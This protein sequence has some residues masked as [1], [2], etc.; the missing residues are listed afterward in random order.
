MGKYNYIVNRV[1]T[2]ST[3][4]TE[5]D[6]VLVG[7]FS[8]NST[9]DSSRDFI[10]LHIYTLEEELLK[11]QLN[12]KGSTQELGSSGAGK[13]GA[14]NIVINPSNDAIAN[15]FTNGDVLLKYNFF[16]DLLQL[17]STPPKY[18]IQN[19]SSDRLEIQLLTLEVSDS[20]LI[21]AVRA[22]KDKL[23]SQS[24][25]SDFKVNFGNNIL[26]TGVNIDTLEFKDNQS[27]IVKLYEP[28]PSKIGVKD[29]CTLLEVVSNSVSFTV[30]V[31]EQ[32]DVVKVPFL[33]GPNF[34]IEVAQ[35]SNVPTEFFNF[36]ELFSYPV[37]SSYYQLYS[38]FNEK[39][40][41]IS[42]DHSDFNDF[43]H[44][45]S[46][47]ERLRNFK[48]KLDLIHSYQDSRDAVKNTGY[49]KLGASGSRE[50]YDGLITGIVNNFDHYD[51]FLYYESGSHA[52]PKSNT[53]HPYI[54]QRSSTTKS[55]EWFNSK[56]TSASNYDVTN[57]DVLTNAIPSY[58]REDSQN[59]PLLMFVH[60]LGQHFDNLWIYFKAVSNKYDADNRL[61]FGISKD[62]VRGAIESFGVKV[63]NSNRN[64]ENLFSA[65]AGESYQSGSEVINHLMVITSGSGVE[66]L[67]PMPAD[68]YQKEIY[69]RIY[70]NL[71]LLTKSKGTFRGL[72]AL[73]NCFGIPDNI[74]PIKQFGGTAIDSHRHF[75][76]QQS[77]TSSYDKV[78]LDN[79]GSLVSGSTLSQHT[80]IVNRV[81]K[82]S[83]DAHT[84]EVGFDISDT[85]NDL[86][87][88]RLSS[89]FDYDEYIGDPRD[90]YETKYHE[91]DKLAEK[92]FTDEEN[93]SIYNYWNYVTQLWNEHPGKWND[94]PF[95]AFRET[96]D[97]IRL[98]KFFD[99]S[100]FRVIKDFVPARSNV[101]TGVVIKPHILNRSKI[102]QVEVSWENKIYTGSIQV[103]PITGSHAGAFDTTPLSPYTTNYSG[104]IISPLG[105]VPRH[106]TD[107]SP[108]YTGEF[109]GSLLIA[110]DGE[111][112]SGNPFK[113]QA[114]PVA[115]FSLRAFNFSL[116]IPL[117][118]D[119]I[120]TVTKVGEFFKFTPIGP[121]S[122]SITYPTSN[123]G[124]VGETI[125]SSIDYNIY[126]FLSAKGTPTY[127]YYF[128]G[129]YDGADIATANLL[130]TGST[131]TIY[132]NTNTSVDHYYGHFS[133][134]PANRVLYFASTRY[135][136]GTADGTTQ[137]G[138]YGNADAI[139][140]IYPTTAGPTGSMNIT[141][142]WN[143]FNQFI[144]RA[145]DDYGGN[146]YTFQGWYDASNNLLAT[147]NTLSV[148]SGSY[149][150][151]E[152][153]YALY[154]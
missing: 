6:A 133:T 35:E 94:S 134:E 44:F 58:L 34:D 105:F 49:I 130:Q 7:P 125:S 13:D 146:A 40:A 54:N 129:W 102:K 114:Q 97:F 61:D 31:E 69:K 22:V 106:V 43:I 41:Q 109:S 8:I 95:A 36:D 120:L 113:S 39:G 37:T 126:Q 127:P 103:D 140:L 32:Q 65:F 131:V 76:S 139:E 110:S 48:Y 72:R 86:I 28:L 108:K 10:D 93:G 99:N 1:D 20:D 47:E 50:Y 96:G 26:S 147:T 132:E 136:D 51:R 119:V 123:T 17:R 29:T 92:I 90:N 135:D 19:I 112:N 78:R 87:Q 128:E 100:I 88:N 121:G 56:I 143:A 2:D 79:T 9:F 118:C 83:D 63:Y 18:F 144:L 101:N 137:P 153:F 145:I 16:S 55:I 82:Y 116:P 11:S 57:Y 46:A 115:Q 42:I 74:L 45:S 124:D 70:H 152:Q 59:E 12:Y 64:L 71:P 151:V 77:V 60:M 81:Y 33:K 80:S 73:I 4:L 117:A 150:G 149:G 5:K 24:F 122:V 25:F 111:L 138:A 3:S 53:K 91:L 141:Q 15:G 68:N 21:E 38:L 52:W 84:V 30:R 27:V 148:T 142:N 62:L 107:E 23:E 85:T 98:I 89:S 67:Q 154:D 14:S 66:H 75:S 104:S